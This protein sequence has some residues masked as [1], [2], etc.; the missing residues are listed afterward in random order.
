MFS[1]EELS[2]GNP[3]SVCQL[4][5]RLFVKLKCS[6]YDLAIVAIFDVHENAG[7]LRAFT[8]SEHGNDN[9]AISTVFDVVCAAVSEQ[10]SPG[11]DGF[12]SSVSNPDRCF[13]WNFC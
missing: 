8:K 2:Y 7:P 6:Q 5:V 1:L 10:D 4:H 13:P 3:K 12:S 9:G 11:G